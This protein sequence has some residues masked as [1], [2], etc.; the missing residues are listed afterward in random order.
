MINNNISTNEKINA[1][2]Y[3]RYS[4]DRQN[5]QSIEG[6]IE[7]CKKYAEQ[8]G[9][10]I[11]NEYADR[12][13]SGKNF[14]RPQFQKMICDSKS[15]E[16]QVILLYKLDRF[17]RNKEETCIFRSLLKKRNIKVLSAT[18]N[19]PEG[20]LGVFIEGILDT[21]N[22]FYSYILAENVKRGMNQN[23]ERCNSNGGSIPFG[24]KTIDKK[25]IADEETAKYVPKIFEMYRDGTMIKDIID[26]LSDLGVKNSRGNKFVYNSINSIL[27]NRKYM[28]IYCFDG[29]EVPDAIPRLISDELFYDVQKKMEKNKHNRAHNKAKEEYLLTSKLFCGH[30]KSKMVGTSAKSHTGKVYRYYVCNKKEDSNCCKKKVSKRNIE[31]Y[32]V[33]KCKEVLTDKN[34]KLIAKELLKLN[35]SETENIKLISL[36]K[37]LSKLN[38][39][40]KN[41]MKNLRD[42]END[43]LK[44]FIRDDMRYIAEKIKD[45]EKQI[46]LEKMRIYYFNESDILHFLNKLKNGDIDDEVYRKTLIDVFVNKVYCYDDK[47][48]LVFN[49]EESI[50][51]LSENNTYEFEVDSTKIQS[52]YNINPGSPKKER[53]CRSFFVPTV[54][55]RTDSLQRQNALAFW[56]WEK[57]PV[58][59][60][61]G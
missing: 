60:L 58:E 27:K 57:A 53:H 9:Y 18:E 24:Y 51:A 14:D 52:L 39:E 43:E 30:C 37:E 33:E 20:S 34:I 12:A 15:N 59:L 41:Q 2:I 47:V 17:G 23:A 3:A 13:C 7:I 56:L 42:E 19:I 10:N 61:I 55:N 22:E 16:F 36:K 26:Y 11:I 48:T 50:S 8:N 6:Q 21:V 1:V 45:T 29:Y 25:Y 5:E 35:N 31:N 28:G 49:I 54:G 38:K 44:R 46:S 32:V 40:M 4:S